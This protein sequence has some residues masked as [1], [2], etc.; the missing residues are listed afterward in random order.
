MNEINNL[1]KAILEEYPRLTEDDTFRFACHPGVPCF[2]ECC[3]DVN[4]FLT[5][6]DILRMKNRLGIS[7][8]EFLDQYTL[9]PLDP[10]LKYPILMLRMQEDEKKRCHFVSPDGCTVYDDRPWAC[11]YYPVGLASPKEGESQVEQEFYF[12]LHEDVC[13]GFE[14]GRDWRIKEW[15]VDQGV[16]RYDE[17]GRLF[18]EITLHKYFQSGRALEPRL[19]EL[20][21]MA[22][23]NLDKFRLFITEST[24]LNRFALE[25]G[26]VEKI[27]T[28]DE[29]LLRFSFTWLKFALFGEKTVRIR[30]AAVRG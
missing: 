5:P 25:P 14:E 7:S 23:Y 15:K 10:N 17:F 6:Y 28:D 20:F 24:F 29:E 3:S 2:N 19:M 27:T 8:M 21:H 9:T 4:I 16:A 18:K 11:R 12:L 26:Q 30:S 13:K 1:K 22:C